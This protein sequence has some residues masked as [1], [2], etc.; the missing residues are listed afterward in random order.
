MLGQKPDSLMVQSSEA[1]PIGAASSAFYKI[2]LQGLASGL[3]A[4][5]HIALGADGEPN[6]A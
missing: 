6:P 3:C 5:W 4:G 1:V 2:F